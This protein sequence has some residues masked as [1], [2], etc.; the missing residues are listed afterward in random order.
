M[1]TS[2]KIALLAVALIVM[3]GCSAQRRAERLVRRAVALCP[4]LV[5]VKAHPIDTVLTAPGFADMARVPLPQV[6]AGDTLYAATDHGTVVVSLS[7]TDSSLRVGFVAAPQKI[8]YKDQVKIAQVTIEPTPQAK[9][10]SFWSHFAL[11]LL[12]LGTGVALCLWLLRYVIKPNK[13]QTP[14]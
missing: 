2:L 14:C 1:K 7:D 10:K 8:R 11:V 4:E 6:L 13:T 9:G 3:N 5:Q 12:G